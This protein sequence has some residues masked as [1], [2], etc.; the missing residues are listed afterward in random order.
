ML[1]DLLVTALASVVIG[2]NLGNWLLPASWIAVVSLAAISK[3][4]LQGAAAHR[5]HGSGRVILGGQ[6]GS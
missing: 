4:L 2:W 3:K 5:P 6:E 1:L